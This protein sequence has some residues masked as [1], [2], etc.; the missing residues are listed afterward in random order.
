MTISAAINLRLDLHAGAQHREL[1][2]YN[3]LGLGKHPEESFSLKSTDNL[4]TQQLLNLS[5]L[6]KEP[7]YHPQISAV[8]MLA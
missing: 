4:L 2:I 6:S 8:A 7:A 3:L 1:S 5:C